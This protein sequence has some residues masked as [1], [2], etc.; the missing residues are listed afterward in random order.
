MEG[1]DSQVLEV[2]LGGMHTLVSAVGL[3]GPLPNGG[4]GPRA[5]LPHT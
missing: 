5:R 4:S 2:E 1:R 3:R